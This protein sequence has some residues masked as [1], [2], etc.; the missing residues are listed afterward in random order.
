MAVEPQEYEDDPIV[1]ALGIT[2]D[3]PFIPPMDRVFGYF[4]KVPPNFRLFLKT[5]ACY[6]EGPLSRIAHK[7]SVSCHGSELWLR[8]NGNYEDDITIVCMV[9]PGETMQPVE[10]TYKA[11]YASYAYA[12]TTPWHEW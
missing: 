1:A 2:Q 12:K 3:V 10:P 11:L 7:G 6:M 5:L 9:D 4:Q 8:T